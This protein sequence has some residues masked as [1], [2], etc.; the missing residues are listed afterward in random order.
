MFKQLEPRHVRQLQIENDAIGWLLPKHRQSLATV[1][2]GDDFDV[3]IAE[4]LGYAQKLCRIVLDDQQPLAR[5]AGD[6]R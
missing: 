5:I 4:Q 3:L 2:G 1:V 6:I